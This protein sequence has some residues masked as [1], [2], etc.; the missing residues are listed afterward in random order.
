[1]TDGKAREQRDKVQLD[2]ELDEPPGKVW[3]AICTPEF[4]KTWLP[5]EDLADLEPVSVMPGRE[6][7]FRMRESTPPY[8]ESAVTFRIEPNEAGGTT[9]RVIHE[10]T[11]A[12]FM[13]TTRVPA[14]SNVPPVMLAA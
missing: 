5:T 13:Q 6:V 12:R 3:R 8:L 10:L 7:R 9:L 2:Y 4:R 14:N 11:D 1:M